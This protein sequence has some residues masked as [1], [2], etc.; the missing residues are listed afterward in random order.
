[1]KDFRCKF[2]HKLL[3]KISFLGVVSEIAKNATVEHKIGQL[4][5]DVKCPK[6]KKINKVT[7]DEVVLMP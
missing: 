5:I 3:F 7:R 2:C 1:M 6:C 4:Q